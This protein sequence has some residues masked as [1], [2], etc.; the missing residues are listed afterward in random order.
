MYKSV[1]GIGSKTSLLNLILMNRQFVRPR[2][3]VIVLTLLFLLLFGIFQGKAAGEAKA[4]FD[5]TEPAEE[6]MQDLF[7]LPLPEPW[8]GDFDGLKNR[9]LIR[10]LVPYSKTFFFLDGPEI[11]GTAHDFGKAFESWLN[12]KYRKQRLRFTVVFVPTTR[13]RLLPALT[14]GLG[15]I[16][17][18]NLTITP[19][20]LQRVDFSYP[21]AENVK[22]VI[23]TGP[24]APSLRKI[25]DLGGKELYVRF[26]SSYYEHL[27]ALNK[28]LKKQIVLKPAEEDLE[29][30]DILEMVNA[31][32]LPMAVLDDH[33]AHFW[34]KVFNQIKVRSDLSVN[35]GGRIGWA[36]RKNSPL[37][38]A[39]IN[40]FLK[41]N[42]LKSG[43]VHDVYHRYLHSTQYVK[44]TTSIT[45]M[46]KYQALLSL[47]QKYGEKYDFE[48]LMLLAQGYQESKLD[49][50]AKSP[51]GA[52]GIMQLLP[53]TAEGY[54]IGIPNVDKSVENNIH[55]GVKYLRWIT[56]T[57][58]DD[59]FLSAKN[60][61][62]MSFAAYNAG[63]GNLKRFRRG[64]K[65]YGLDDNIWF[66]N[67]EHAAARIVGRETVQYV[68]N[69]YKYY[70]AYRLIEERRSARTN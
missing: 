9:R 20:R 38:L 27:V 67:V 44:N 19:A 40:G 34:A 6:E 5:D 35:T 41:N 66:G 55:A 30:E 37:L 12:N 16:A 63:P 17:V 33:K 11:R 42:A 53:S 43:L 26:S 31:G 61:T 69:I 46:K 1:W 57:Y 49:Q 25:E 50:Q 39:E 13:D 15:D 21:L 10:I 70:I 68:G 62:L 52:V 28:K 65:K 29:D 45:E 59:P 64:A 58:L 3:C 51:K 23:V 48:Y 60:K 18:A 7:I 24:S 36:V 56:D 8:Q 22:E 4:P 32:L 47:F 2:E 54:P 14:E